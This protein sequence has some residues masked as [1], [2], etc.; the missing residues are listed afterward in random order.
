MIAWVV[1]YRRHRRQP[2]KSPSFYALSLPSSPLNFQLQQQ[3]LSYLLY[4]QLL[5][6]SYPQRRCSIPF[7][8]SHFRTLFHSTEGC[9][10]A[11]S[12]NRGTTRINQLLTLALSTPY[13]TPASSPRWMLPADWRALFRKPAH[14]NSCPSRGSATP[15]PWPRWPPRRVAAAI[16]PLLADAA[17]LPSWIPPPA[18]VSAM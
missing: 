16:T 12:Q 9:P 8:F 17:A 13:R 4:F 11:S 2:R 18:F 5:P 6:H 7:L 1:I 15:S 3:F 10:C 14:P